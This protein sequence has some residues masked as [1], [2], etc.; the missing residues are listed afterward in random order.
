MS[1]PKTEQREIEALQQAMKE[2]NIRVG[3]IVTLDKEQEVKIGRNTIY[4]V[5]LRNFLLDKLEGFK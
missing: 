4:Y 5:P 1:N 2:L 3:T